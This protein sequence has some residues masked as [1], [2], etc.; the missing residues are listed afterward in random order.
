[1]LESERRM[2]E[3][4][5]L[6][7]YYALKSRGL[8][9]SIH[10]LAHVT[11]DQARTL[12]DLEGWEGD[13]LAIAD[14]LS[15]LEGFRTA[16]HAPLVRAARALDTEALAALF[17]RRLHIALAPKE[18][19]SEGDEPLPDWLRN[20][21]EGL[22]LLQTPDGRFLIAARAVDA[23]V[24]LEGDDFE[25]AD[26]EE[27]KQ[28]VA[29]V[30]ELYLDE[31]WEYVAGVLRLA[32]SDL[33]TVLEDE[34]FALRVGRMKDLGFPS[35]EEALEVY[36]PLPPE[37]LSGPPTAVALT[38]HDEDR[39]P[40]I[41]VE[42]FG[43]SALDEALRAQGGERERQIEADLLHVAN[44]MVVADGVEPADIAGVQEV[45]E[46]L[47]GGLVLGLTVGDPDP[48]GRAARLRDHHPRILFRVGQGRVMSLVRRARG[49]LDH[50]G[51]G[52]LG[53]DAWDAASRSVFE[54]LLAPRPATVAGLR[55][56]PEGLVLNPEGVETR[57]PFR[58]PADL[59]ATEAWLDELEALAGAS[60]ELEVFGGSLPEDVL[61]TEPSERDL[62][63]R[64][65]TQIAGRL[66]GQEETVPLNP[67]M[68]LALVDLVGLSFP[69][70]RVDGADAL[71]DAW[72]A[73]VRPAYR[74]A[75]RR[76]GETLL[77]L[78]AERLFP[79]V[80]QEDVDVR[81][82]EGL[83]RRE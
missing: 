32:H 23:R 48:E 35:R 56:G 13:G 63:H 52:G 66:L 42:T 31:D 72:V 12:L 80:G 50:P 33:V 49:L 67:A 43:D 11:T 27:Q 76:R 54:A 41:H 14:L 20:P 28:V 44:A 83:L 59:R 8:A 40:L 69:S 37:A 5:P 77:G 1:M 6:E 78:M 45:L 60:V 82:L 36:A 29:L 10:A 81:Y 68:G 9:D 47:R 55:L 53:L 46:R 73:Q 16:G 65:S 7:A 3:A 70:G 18:D 30:R 38:V 25:E 24:E 58:D 15:W 62:D 74:G 79:L 19:R 64:L 61:P 39:L 22:E 21:P 17:R 34:A 2:A 4:T 51:L 57:R 71:L 26:E 75:L